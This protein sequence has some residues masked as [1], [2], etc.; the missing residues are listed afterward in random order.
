MTKRFY[1]VMLG[2]KSDLAEKCRV[3]G[4]IGTDFDVCEDLTGQLPDDWREF[5]Q[6][7]IEK[8]LPRKKSRVSAGMA[9]GALWVVSKGIRQ[10]DIVLCP[11]TFPGELIAGE[12]IGDEREKL[13]LGVGVQLAGEAEQHAAVL[14]FKATPQGHGQSL[15]ISDGS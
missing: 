10:G 5:N 14:L 12:V 15:Q 11:T 7:W 4:F 2:K 9:A 13:F 8:L 1:K 3:E 6:Q